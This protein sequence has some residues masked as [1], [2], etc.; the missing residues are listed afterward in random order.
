[1]LAVAGQ[2]SN[3]Q[4]DPAVPG[5]G[6]IARAEIDRRAAEHHIPQL[7]VR[8]ALALHSPGRQAPT[9]TGSTPCAPSG[10]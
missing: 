6:R 3:F 1:M 8:G 4:A 2:E 7:L 5:L 10:R 9:P